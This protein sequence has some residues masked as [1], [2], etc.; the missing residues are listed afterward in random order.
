MTPFGTSRM[1]DYIWLGC[2]GTVNYYLETMIDP[3]N[4]GELNI[5][6][7]I[8]L[9]SNVMSQVESL[10]GCI[11]VSKKDQGKVSKI[12]FVLYEYLAKS[13]VVLN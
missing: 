5:G 10:S 2:A 9:N 13:F 12:T 4:I 6:L 11:H 1:S 3:D 8:L 7:L